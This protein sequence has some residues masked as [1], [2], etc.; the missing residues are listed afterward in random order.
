MPTVGVRGLL[1]LPMTLSLLA[2]KHVLDK[3]R[4]V[5]LLRSVVVIS[6]SYLILFGP[7]AT[8][9]LSIGYILCLIATTVALALAP[10]EWF[11]RLDFS[12]ALLLGD[13]A[14]VLIGLYL[15]VGCFSQDFLIIYFFT[16]FLT[17]ATEGV[18]QIGLGAAM[19]SVL[20]GY[21]LWMTTAHSLGAG[22]WLR[23]PFFFVVA[24]FYAYMTE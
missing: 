3:K 17:A 6:T 20:Y 23:L 5:V 10:K 4:T 16:I 2:E 7:A 12:A 8:N 24:V 19:V 1:P 14:V 21:W 13:T 22:E 18:A 11:H 9:P 15:T